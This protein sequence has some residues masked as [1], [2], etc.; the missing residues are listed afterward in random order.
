MRCPNCGS[1]TN[2]EGE[3]CARCGEGSVGGAQVLAETYRT[4]RRNTILGVLL[5]LGACLMMLTLMSKGVPPFLAF[6][7]TCWIFLWGMI[8]L[9]EG[10]NQWFSARRQI[11]ASAYAVSQHLGEQEIAEATDQAHRRA[12]RGKRRGDEGRSRV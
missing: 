10:G 5:L 4:G 9:A 11:K 8:A 7:W 1:N 12:G 3:S 2:I 6:L